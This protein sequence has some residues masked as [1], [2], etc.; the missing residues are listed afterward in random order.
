MSARAR[1]QRMHGRQ[2]T[3]QATRCSHPLGCPELAL[4]DSP[5]CPHHHVSGTVD[6]ST[7]ENEATVRR[8]EEMR[9]RRENPSNP[10]TKE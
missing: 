2:P 6:W 3:R 8:G 7:V 9:A 10:S 1:K 5:Y 4:A